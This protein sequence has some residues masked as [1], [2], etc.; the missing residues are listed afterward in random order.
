M[1]GKMVSKPNMFEHFFG[2]S[3]NIG[4]ELS[5]VLN[6]SNHRQLIRRRGEFS[7]INK[8]N[9]EIAGSRIIKEPISEFILY[10]YVP[11]T[12]V[13]TRFLTPYKT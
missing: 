1:L 9:T 11:L 5:G 7:R 4:R 2:A 6:I 8:G 3:E 13:Y 12:T 10:V